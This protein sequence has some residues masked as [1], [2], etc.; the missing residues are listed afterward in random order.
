ME[1]ML[2]IEGERFALEELSKSFTSPKLC[3]SKEG[4]DFFLRSSDL[5]LLKNPKEVFEIAKKIIS[6]INGASMLIGFGMHT[7]LKVSNSITKINDDGSRNVS[8]FPQ[9]LH[10]HIT[11]NSFSVVIT[12]PDG[13]KREINRADPIPLWISIAQSNDSVA[14]VLRLFSNKKDWVNLYRI[15]EIIEGDVGGMDNI[16]KND[17][18]N[19]NKIELFKHTAN[20]VG[21]TGDQAR[22]GK[23]KTTPPKSPMSIFDAEFLITSIILSWLKSK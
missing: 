17:W 22:H 3:I 9:P 2:K 15:Y 14:K 16:V 5:N 6:C 1:W 13:T 21:A 20:S 19:K 18:T 7:S 4:Q 11:T 8:I 23:E 10:L 12:N